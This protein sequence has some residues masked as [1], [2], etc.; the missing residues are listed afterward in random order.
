MPLTTISAYIKNQIN[1]FKGEDDFIVQ[2]VTPLNEMPCYNQ[3]NLDQ[4]RTD[5][6]TSSEVTI[7]TSYIMSLHPTRRKLRQIDS[8]AETEQIQQKLSSILNRQDNLHLPRAFPADVPLQ[9]RH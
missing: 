2:F 7:K 5:D 8:S 9:L 6:L 3:I 4:L 1:E